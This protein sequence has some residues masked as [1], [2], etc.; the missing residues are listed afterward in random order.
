[1]PV[2]AV[3]KQICAIEETKDRGEDFSGVAHEAGPHRVYSGGVGGRE[4]PLYGL[5]R[6]MLCS[7]LSCRATNS[8]EAPRF[9]LFVAPSYARRVSRLLKLPSPRPKD[10]QSLG[11]GTRNLAART[12]TT[13]LPRFYGTVA[14]LVAKNGYRL[15]QAACLPESPPSADSLSIPGRV[16]T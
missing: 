8:G 1:M 13:A 10:L 5:A 4:P 7:G 12:T 2:T 6:L 15:S 11:F 14:A 16:T 3:G 9:R